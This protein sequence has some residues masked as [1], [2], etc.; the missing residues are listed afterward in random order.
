MSKLTKSSLEYFELLYSDFLC[1]YK[2][3]YPD[4]L[5]KPKMHFLF[6][7]NH[8]QTKR[9][10]KGLLEDGFKRMDGAIK[11]HSHIMN[12]LRNQQ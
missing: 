12:N 6:F 5:V 7:I 8:R 3:L 2:W 11:R 10:A 4:I 1:E 9:P